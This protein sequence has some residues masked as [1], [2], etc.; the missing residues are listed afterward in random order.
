M[1]IDLEGALEVADCLFGLLHLRVKELAEI[2]QDLLAIEIVGRDV[3]RAGQ[4]RAHLLPV[5]ALLVEARELAHRPDVLGVELDYLRVV[6]L[7]ILRMAEI[8]AVPL[9]EVQTE[10]DLVLR[11]C[12]LLQPP[13]DGLDD[14]SPATGRLGHALEV[15]SRLAVVEV[16]GERIDE[17]VEGLVLVLELLFEDAGD[18]PEKLGLVSGVFARFEAREIELHQRLPASRR[19]VKPLQ[20]GERLVMSGVNLE[21]FLVRCARAI[22]IAGLFAPQRSNAAE[23]GYAVVGLPERVR[24]PHLDV[25]N[26]RPLFFRAIDG[27]ER[28]HRLEVGADI[29]ELPPGVRQRRRAAA[30]SHRTSCQARGRPL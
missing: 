5:R 20:L 1:R 19:L 17:R 4:G 10:T 29:E 21:D 8:V 6:G 13:V 24:A 2:V 3:Q 9:G 27:L 28:V 30:A 16:D 26:V 22:R 23:L 25:D 14:F 15:A 18:L 11:I 7:R 12:L